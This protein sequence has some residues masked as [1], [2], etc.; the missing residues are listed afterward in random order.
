MKTVFGAFSLTMMVTAGAAQAAPNVI[1]C[2]KWNQRVTTGSHPYTH[3]FTAEE[4]GGTLPDAN[5]AGSWSK[6]EVCGVEASFVLTQPWEG[7]AGYT[8]WTIDGCDSNVSQIQA[9]FVH[10]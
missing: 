1:V 6:Q 8:F 4:C 9:V 7:A 10:L 5:Y 3:T 2:S